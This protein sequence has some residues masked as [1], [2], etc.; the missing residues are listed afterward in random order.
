MPGSH[1]EEIVGD[2]SESGRLGRSTSRRTP[3]RSRISTCRHCLR[4]VPKQPET[5]ARSAVRQS[6]HE[7]GG[8]EWASTVTGIPISAKS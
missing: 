5:A 2:Y 7:P 4:V 8:Y 3:S 6:A 1:A